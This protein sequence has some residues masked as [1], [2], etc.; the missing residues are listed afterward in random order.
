[1]GESATVVVPFPFLSK[2]QSENEN[3]DETGD[4][5]TSIYSK[6][7]K[8]PA[9]LKLSRIIDLE[10]SC[11]YI[12]M[13]NIKGSSASALKMSNSNTNLSMVPPSIKLP[14][15]TEEELDESRGTDEDEEEDQIMFVSANSSA[16]SEPRN[17]FKDDTCAKLYTEE[18]NSVIDEGESSESILPQVYDSRKQKIESLRLDL[19]LNSSSGSVGEGCSTASNLLSVGSS[20]SG[21]QSNNNNTLWYDDWTI[22]DCHFGLPLFDTTVNQIVSER[23]VSNNLW[24]ESR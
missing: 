7:A 4:P 23:I 17:G 8:H 18:L 22:L 11:G 10:R 19:T 6:W 21:N 5:I 15:L 1:M 13:M 14:N 3:S 16:V 2:S 24:E 20:N 9:I 12:T